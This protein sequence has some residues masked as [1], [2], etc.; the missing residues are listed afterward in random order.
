MIFAIVAVLVLVWLFAVIIE[1][2]GGSAY[3]LLVVAALLS[4][5]RRGP[6]NPSR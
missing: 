4:V 2:G 5:K 3:L 1:F 6:G